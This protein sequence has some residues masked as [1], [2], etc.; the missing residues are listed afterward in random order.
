MSNDQDPM[1]ERASKR[2]AAVGHWSLDI[3]HWL[4]R[5]PQRASVLV[6]VI[7]LLMFTTFA[8]IAFME[9]A[10]NDLLVDQRAAISRRLRAEA[11]SALEVT[12]AVLNDF[13]E[14]NNGLRSPAEGWGDPL[15]F[16]GYTPNEDRTVEVTFEDESGKISLPHATDVVL[17]NLFKTW[18]LADADGA[19]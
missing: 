3:G 17:K 8:L 6:I 9:R 2:R 13:R 15:T 12:L 10:S 18:G 7:V 11:Y 1:K 19:R 4:F 14:V 16:A 5:R